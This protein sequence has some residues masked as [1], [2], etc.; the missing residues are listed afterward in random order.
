MARPTALGR[1]ARDVQEITFFLAFWADIGWSSC[2]DKESTLTTFPVSLATLRTNIADKLARCCISAQGTH[3]L[4]YFLFHLNFLPPFVF[5]PVITSPEK[6]C[7]DII[8]AEQH[9]ESR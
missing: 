4:V 7:D 1:I 8:P 2:C 9:E 6:W 3:M 5:L